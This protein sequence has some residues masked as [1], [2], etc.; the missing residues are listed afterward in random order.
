MDKIDCE[1]KSGCC[2]TTWKVLYDWTTKNCKVVCSNCGKESK[3]LAIRY[4][5]SGDSKHE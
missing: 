4:L 5:N 1:V 2:G 3:S